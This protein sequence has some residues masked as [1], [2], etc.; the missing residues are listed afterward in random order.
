MALMFMMQKLKKLNHEFSKENITVKKS[1]KRKTK[2]KR[3]GSFLFQM[4]KC[5][6]P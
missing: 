6:R 3:T 2:K 5:S 1:N 4:G